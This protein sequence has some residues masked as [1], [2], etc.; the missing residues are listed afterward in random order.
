MKI[1]TRISQMQRWALKHR[2]QGIGFVPTMGA[3]HDG[4]LSLV[5]ACRKENRFCVASIF[6]N[7]SQFGPGEDLKNYPRTFSADKA[8]LL[9]EKVDILFYPGAREMYPD[10]FQTEVRVKELAHGLCGACRP[11][12]FTGVAAVVAKL[13]NIV[14]PSRAYF[15]AKDYQQA[16]VIKRMAQDLNFPIG[17]RVLDTVREKDGLAMSS[18]NKYLSR[19]ERM[20]APLIYLSMLYAQEL[21]RDGIKDARKLKEAVGEFLRPFVAKIDYIELV[22]P[23]NL[24]PVATIGRVSLLAIACYIGKTRLIDN[25]TLTLPAGRQA[26]F[27]LPRRGREVRGDGEGT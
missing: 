6:V 25:I 11:V 7:P 8:L 22:C 17:I 27:P 13:F 10:G 9:K 18:R 3:L 26:F 4:H 15:G 5:R 24:R 14:Q 12:H 20:K 19:P 16:V 1:I 2:S 23:E 21:L